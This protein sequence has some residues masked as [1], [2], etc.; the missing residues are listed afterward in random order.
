[1]EL[2]GAVP[3]LVLKFGSYPLNYGGLGVVR[4]LGRAGVS[5]DAVVESRNTPL[6]RS[7][8]VRKAFTWRTRGGESDDELLTGLRWIGDRVGQRAVLV[9]T[10]DEAA[11][12][13]ARYAAELDG[14][15]LFPRAPEGLVARLASKRG[16]HQIATE[17]GV[18]RPE[19]A[20][21]RTFD[22]LASAAGQVGFPLAVKNSEPWLRLRRPAV[23]QTTYVASLDQLQTLARRW[24]E[25]YS[26]I[27]QAHL[28]REHCEDWFFQGYFD[29]SSRCLAGFT[30]RKYR[31][32]P[33][34]AGVTACGVLAPK[35]EL[36]EETAR[37]CLALG[38]HG[39]AD[40]D[41][42]FDRR[43]GRFHLLDFNPRPG[44]HFRL[45]EDLAG[46]DVVR[47][48]HLDLTGRPTEALGPAARRFVAGH[49]DPI[50]RLASRKTAERPL[51]AP[52]EVVERA[53]W[54]VDDPVPAATALAWIGGAA[55]HRLGSSRR[56]VVRRPGAT[57]AVETPTT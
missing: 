40:V 38:Y 46:L 10:D 3:A 9:T 42:R 47:A 56:A 1:M 7:R 18:A 32:W 53:W 11:T 49:L 57:A 15:F 26:V 34:E 6:A 51:R 24:A 25:P 27:L 29:S 50:A 8:Y 31:S 37:L 28:A 23:S 36:A 45:F 22:E 35:P 33:H 19:A 48:L 5:V 16:L 2:D 17:H 52:G 39:A 41:W 30:G 20:F 21:P 55:V 12:F 43:D 4:S 13:V 44:A 54:A 14:R